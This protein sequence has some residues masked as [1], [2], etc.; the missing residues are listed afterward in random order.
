MFRYL[1]VNE[2]GFA[3]AG[4]QRP[5]IRYALAPPFEKP[6]ASEPPRAPASEVTTA[7]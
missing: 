1:Q 2:L 5:R 3:A 7:S 6:G 4:I